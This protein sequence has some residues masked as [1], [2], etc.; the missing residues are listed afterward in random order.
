M[1]LTSSGGGSIK[2]AGRY[3]LGPEGACSTSTLNSQRW[4]V[5]DTVL[6]VSQMGQAFLPAD[7]ESSLR[8]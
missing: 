7:G 2:G 1:T 3:T 6:S 8:P 5:P 4:D